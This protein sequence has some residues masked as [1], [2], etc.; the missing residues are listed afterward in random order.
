M[1]NWPLPVL[2]A[3]CI[4]VS[5]CGNSDSSNEHD[6]FPP[7]VSTSV[8]VTDKIIDTV[9]KPVQPGDDGK[10]PPQKKE[11]DVRLV[12]SFISRGFGI[13]Q[14]LKSDFES[15]LVSRPEARYEVHPWG[16][17]GELNYC[18]PLSYLSAA[19]QGTFVRDVKPH[20]AGRQMVYVNEHT[21]CDNWK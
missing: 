8:T 12:V 15:W 11:E 16:K 10:V 17:E 9:P 2:A 1:K 7:A 19:D 20:F 21:R 4:T 6:S 18:F 14:K 3:I 5:S 13:D